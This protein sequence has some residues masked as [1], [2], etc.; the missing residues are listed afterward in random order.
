M[1][2]ELLTRLPDDRKGNKTVNPE[3]TF[4][5]SQ[6]DGRFPDS[7]LLNLKVR[8]SA[9]VRP[10]VLAVSQDEKLVDDLLQLQQYWY[11]HS[12]R[13]HLVC[14]IATFSCVADDEIAS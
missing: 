9:A 12:T 4:F 6:H 14:R 7:G 5:R 8:G 10:S 13:V 11:A 3:I 2:L 1:N